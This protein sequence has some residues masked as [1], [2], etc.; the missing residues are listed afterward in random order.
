MPKRPCSPVAP[1]SAVLDESPRRALPLADVRKNPVYRVKAEMFRTLGHPARLRLLELL[2]DGERTVGELQ[3]ALDLDSSGASQHLSALRRQGLLDSHKL[4]TTVYCRL[5]DRR[6]LELLALVRAI[7]AGKLQDSQ[8]LLDELGTGT[9]G[10]RAAV[11]A[12]APPVVR[13]A[14]DHDR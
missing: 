7:V 2:G 8:L 3:A 5:R 1:S 12:H 4:G 9:D 6:T 13:Q 10:D 14:P 11:A